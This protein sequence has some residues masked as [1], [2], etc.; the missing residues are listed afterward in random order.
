MFGYKEGRDVLRGLSFTVEKG[1]VT[2]L[3]GPTGAGKTTIISLLLRYY[4]CP[5]ETVFLDDT[6]IRDFTSA[7]LR[8][9]M[10]FVSQETL[11][12]HDT[13][14]ANITYGLGSVPEDRL[15]D[16]VTRARLRDFVRSL[17]QGLDT[18]IGDRG[19]KLSGGEKQRV[20]IARALLKGAD[21]LILDEAT[22]SLDSKTEKLIQEAIEEAIR[23]KTA[24]V[25]AHRLSTIRNADKIV[26]I[27]DG[28]CVEEGRLEELLAKKGRFAEYWEEQKFI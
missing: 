2:A 16:V 13:L 3:V 7:S 19:V 18:L 15:E 10:A 8:S 14:R 12:F 28:R 11:L 21:I 4:D 24:I 20:S 26:V 1:T 23:G 9:H 17:P 6:D 25:I 22:S 27:E 5:P